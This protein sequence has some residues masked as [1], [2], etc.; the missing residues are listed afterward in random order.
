[1]PNKP[2]SVTGRK[3]GLAPDEIEAI[4]SEAKKTDF[5]YYVFF[6]ITVSLGLRMNETANIKMT[7]IDFKFNQVRITNSKLRSWMGTKDKH[8]YLPMN[9]RMI[10]LI[11]EL[12]KKSGFKSNYEGYLFVSRRDKEKKMDLNT[13]G[14]TFTKYARRCKIR[15]SIHALRHY[16]GT[17][18][19]EKTGDINFVR[20]FL[21]HKSLRATDVYVHPSADYIRKKIEEVG[22]IV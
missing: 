5:Q 7:D 22:P 3:K 1:M 8:T 18:L 17:Q 2:C 13:V 21:R 20:N 11:K 16:C 9:P 10:E 6:F 12:V 19:Y 15:A 14:K 4:L